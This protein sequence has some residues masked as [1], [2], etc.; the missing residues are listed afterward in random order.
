[1]TQ[2]HNLAPDFTLAHDPENKKKHRL[3]HLAASFAAGMLALVGG[4]SGKTVEGPAI[5]PPD[6]SPG[7]AKNDLIELQNQ[8]WELKYKLEEMQTGQ[9]I[10]IEA[11]SRQKPPL[12]REFVEALKRNSGITLQWI[13]TERR[14]KLSVT[15]SSE[16]VVS[17]SGK[18][19]SDDGRETLLM[20]GQVVL[21]TPTAFIVLGTIDIDLKYYRDEGAA[22][23]HREGAFT[24]RRTGDRK[25]WRLL[26]KSEH[27]DD[28][29]DYIDIF[30]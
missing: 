26:E 1:M 2:T 21:N 13:K 7:L 9:A 24:F 23:C 19:V 29:T 25:Y 10:F 30:L 3:K 8:I 22:P 4:C 18:H 12:D 11:L 17:I 16:G 5:A 28:G 14:G 15:E 6:P 20:E 27:C